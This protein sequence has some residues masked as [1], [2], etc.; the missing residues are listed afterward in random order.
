[1][2]GRQIEGEVEALTPSRQNHALICRKMRDATPCACPML[3]SDA[4]VG[5]EQARISRQRT[6]F[7]GGPPDDLAKTHITWVT[8]PVLSCFGVRVC[9]TRMGSNC[10]I[11]DYAC[12]HLF[13]KYILPTWTYTLGPEMIGQACMNCSAKA[14]SGTYI[15]WLAQSAAG[16]GEGDSQLGDQR[17]LVRSTEYRINSCIFNSCEKNV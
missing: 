17:S 6:R 10:A 9:H 5:G 11:T 8:L 15:I 12:S 14:Q 16:S 2:E 3:N 4:V 13:Q 1:M 7:T